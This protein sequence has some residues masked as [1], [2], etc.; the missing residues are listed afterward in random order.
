MKNF[1]YLWLAGGLFLLGSCSSEA[2]IGGEPNLPEEGDGEYYLRVSLGELSTRGADEYS[3]TDIENAAFLFYNDKG[4][5]ISTRYVSNA[6]LTDAQKT[7]NA[8]VDIAWLDSQTG[9]T[10]EKCAVIKLSKIPA[11]V[12]C[13]VNAES[14]RIFNT[15]GNTDIDVVKVEKFSKGTTKKFYMSSSSYYEDGNPVY[16]SEIDK[17]LVQS[18]TNGEELAKSGN[19]AVRLQVEPLVAKVQVLNALSTPAGVNPM[20]GD[21]ADQVEAT[22]VTFVP[23][24]VCLTGTTTKGYTIKKLPDWADLNANERKLNKPLKDNVPQ[25]R[26]AIVGDIPSDAD[27]NYPTKAS[28]FEVVDSKSQ[29]KADYAYKTDDKG[30]FFFPFENNNNEGVS[31]TNV[32]VLGKYKVVTSDNKTIENQTFYLFGTGDKFTVYT[33]LK[34]VITKMGGEVTKEVEKNGEKVIEDKSEEE[35]NAMLEEDCTTAGKHTTWTGWMKLK[36]STSPFKCIKYNGGYGYYAA[37]I[38]IPNR[39]NMIVRNLHYKLNIKTING[40]G[41]GIPED[42][43]PIIPIEVPDPS[44][45]NYYMHIAVDVL[46]WME[47]DASNVEWM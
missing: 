41:V 31:A 6:T 30:Q 35:L 40:M 17:S 3:T 2:P 46:D 21:R 45:Q 4:E 22:S 38:A 15:S 11:Y 43:T 18:G 8:G 26:I 24:A 34:E 9:H 12:A 20:D 5:Y 44:N 19:A 25:Q 27:F 10:G 32:V 1:N 37:P 29:A 16:W 42:S 13:V 39:Y 33:S 36:N 47:L 28:L 14:N 7:A 23:E